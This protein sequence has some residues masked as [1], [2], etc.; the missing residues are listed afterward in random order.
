MKDRRLNSN[1]EVVEWERP[2]TIPD[3]FIYD[4]EMDAYYPSG[5]PSEFDHEE[6]RRKFEEAVNSPTR[7]RGFISIQ[8]LRAVEALHAA[9]AKQKP[10]R[11]KADRQ[12]DLFSELTDEDDAHSHGDAES[13][14]HAEQ[15][16]EE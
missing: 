8:Q 11:A 1:G 10:P 7:K 15:D 9:R 5:E 2:S 6:W 12:R 16:S 13:N 3:D 14:D 4:P